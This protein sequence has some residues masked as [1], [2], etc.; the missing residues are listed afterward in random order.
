MTSPAPIAET[1]DSAPKPDPAAV[2]ALS[3]D[4]VSHAY[5][6]RR[7]LSDVS[8]NVA[9]ASFTALLGL[10][11]AGKSTLFSLIT[12]LFGIQ[13]GHVGIFGHDVSSMPG[14]ALRLLGVV[15]QP[16]TL[17]LDLSLTQNLLYHAALH[18]IGRRDAA[19]RAAELLDRIRLAERAG[20][21]V[22]D[23]SGGQM[24]RLEIA[25]ALLHRPRLLLL[26]EPTVGLDVK[27]R[28]DIISH[29]R[30]L[31]TEQGIGVLW[32][33]HLFD[34]IAPGDDLV[35]L[36]QG[37]VLAKGPVGRVITDAGAQDVN[38]AF[39]RLTGAQVMPGG[40]A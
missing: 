15:F 30:Q 18:G 34:E 2:P 1:R 6:P 40:G 25:R 10:N 23:L 9:P 8:F 38:T 20:S 7:A 32:A 5:G 14:E 4:G 22:R 35:V 21:K 13:S 12:R 39:M 11:G 26:D 19:A 16:R 37:K 28:A 3:I 29:V 17:D 36:H 27:A 31:V 33:T 24:R